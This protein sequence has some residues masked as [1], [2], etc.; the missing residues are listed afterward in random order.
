MQHDNL[1]PECEGTGGLT[2]ESRDQWGEV[3]DWD[4]IACDT[5]GGSGV[6]TV[7]VAEADAPPAWISNTG[8]GAMEFGR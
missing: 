4:W 2:Y 3:L 7:P 1:C 8:D 5:C 6:L